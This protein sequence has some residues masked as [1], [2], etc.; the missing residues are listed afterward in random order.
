MII[1]GNDATDYCIDRIT[2]LD[3]GMMFLVFNKVL[4]TRSSK[5]I[6]F[7]KIVQDEETKVRTWKQYHKIDIEGFISYTRGNIRVQVISEYRIY[8]YIIDRETL[9][10]TLENTMG[11][12]MQCN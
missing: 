12:Y 6:L 3:L 4:M 11:N 2:E 7:F 1:N 10:P 9:E 5:Q 8:F